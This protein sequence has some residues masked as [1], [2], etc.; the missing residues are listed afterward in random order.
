MTCYVVA[1]DLV[2]PGQ[3]YDS[4]YNQIKSYKSWCHP[5][6]STWFIVSDKSATKIRSEI[7]AEMDS[8]DKLFV[9]KVTRE[10]AWRNLSEKASNWLKINLEN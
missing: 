4:L 2:S 5:M 6:E 9:G 7:R 8:N 1:Y 3:D 10:A